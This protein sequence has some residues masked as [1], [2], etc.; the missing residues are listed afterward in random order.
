MVDLQLGELAQRMKES[1]L[2]MHLTEPARYWLAKKGYDRQFGARP[3]RRAVQRYIETPLSIHLLKGD[4]N[5]GDLVVIDE[6]EDQLEFTRPC[7]AAE[8]LCQRQPGSA[9]QSRRSL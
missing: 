4:F 2:S 5:A 3:L 8:R 7:R 1:G 6:R 9:R